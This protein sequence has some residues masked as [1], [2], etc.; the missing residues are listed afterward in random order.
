M[1]NAHTFKTDK[2][3]FQ[4]TSISP[5]SPGEKAGLK[6]AED[7]ILTMNGQDIPFVDPEQIMSTVKVQET[8]HTICVVFLFCFLTPDRTRYY[9]PQNSENRPV[10]LTVYNTST[11]RIRDVVLTPSADWPGEGLL[12]IKI[13]LNTYETSYIDTNFSNVY[14]RVRHSH[15]TLILYSYW[16]GFSHSFS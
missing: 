10:L 3:G 1:G 11:E 15:C 8:F 7:F 14:S 4:V 16:R 5:R 12:G 9:P 13:K 2:I 6:V